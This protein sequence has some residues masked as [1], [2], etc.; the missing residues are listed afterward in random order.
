[1]NKI[2]FDTEAFKNL[3]KSQNLSARKLGTIGSENYIGW[4]SKTINRAV[5]NGYMSEGLYN[6]L[7]DQVDIS[8]IV[9]YKLTDDDYEIFSRIRNL[10]IK[11]DK[12]ETRV[13]ILE[14]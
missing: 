2:Y 6:A 8:V 4:S 5:K 14:Q 7:M 13:D 12:L 1:M 3:L 9:L 10:E 11:L